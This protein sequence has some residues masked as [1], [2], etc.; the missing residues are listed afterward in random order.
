MK[1]FLKIVGILFLFMT[2]C[3]TGGH[4]T[5]EE[6]KE[7]YLHAKTADSRFI[8][9][10]YYQGTDEKY[11]YFICRSIDVW[12]PMKVTK[13]EILIDDIKPYKSSSNTSDFPGYYIV[14]P[15]KNY[16]KTTE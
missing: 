3:Q 1:S 7:W 4:W 8:S 10:L 16:S 2:G 6:L 15:E 5:A 12:V 11:H 14:D 13:E 9:P